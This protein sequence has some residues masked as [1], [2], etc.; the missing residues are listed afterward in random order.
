MRMPETPLSGQKGRKGSGP[1]STR[2]HS[3]PMVTMNAASTEPEIE[4][5]PP[6]TTII[7]MS[8]V[9]ET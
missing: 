7:R 1:S 5:M 9:R 6:M 8:Y 4:P 2:S 3:C